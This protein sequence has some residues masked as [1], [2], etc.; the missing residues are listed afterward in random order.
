MFGKVTDDELIE[1]ALAGHGRAWE[2]LVKRYERRLYNFALR[3]MSNRED[4]L[5]V[6]QDVFLSVYRNLGSYRGD[7]AFP[8]WLFRI[9]TFRSTDLLRK[10]TRQFGTTDETDFADDSTPGPM[11]SRANEDICRTLQLLPLDQRQVIELKFFQNFTFDEISVQLGISSNT[12][13]SR[14]YAA[15]RKLKDSEDASPRLKEAT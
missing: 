12:A 4:A 9:A 1:K 6:V 13:K 2:S 14:L 7:G 15:L 11:Q 3:M 8:A 5:D 10:R